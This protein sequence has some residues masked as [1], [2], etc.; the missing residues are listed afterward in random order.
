M[1]RWLEL[2]D[3]VYARRHEYLDLTLGLVVGGE[4]CLV[5]DTGGDEVQGARFAAAVR[6]VTGAPWLVALTHAHFD[7]HFGTRPFLPCPV[8][9]HERCR[10]AMGADREEWVSEFRREGKDELAQRLREAEL[11]AP[12]STFAEDVTLDLGGRTVT[13]LHPGRGHT[14]HDVAV[15]VP[16]AD[17]LFA[18]DLVEAPP[19]VGAD[20]HVGDW[21]HALDR[22]LAL[23]PG[24]IVPGHGDPVAAAFVRRQREELSRSSADR[25]GSA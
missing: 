22:L 5:V 1:T 24:T 16:D 17:V 10:A 12:T 3:G 6:E 11:V 8:W 13:L 15:H 2:G 7:H 9:A 23:R 14:D 4:R 21:P 25:C 18:G 19:S 20:S